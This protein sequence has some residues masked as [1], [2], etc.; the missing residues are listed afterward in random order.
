[1]STYVTVDEAKGQLSIDAG[2]DIHN[3]RIELLIGAAEDWAE[4]YTQRE[5]GEL[6]V[7]DSPS[8]DSQ[9]P[10]PD[11]VDPIKN[12]PDRFP[13][14]S[15]LDCP[16]SEWMPADFRHYWAHVGPV[17]LGTAKPLRRDVKAAILLKVESLFDRNTDNWQLLEKTAMTMLDPYRIGLGV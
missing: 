10:L 3:D 5:L 15:Y 9:H 4:N 8:D 12:W 7:L 11:P 2:L 1:M 13:R 6:M 17:E 16:I 14:P